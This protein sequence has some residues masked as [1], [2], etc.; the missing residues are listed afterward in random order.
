MQRDG[1]GLLDGSA[2]MEET[3]PEED[4]GEREGDDDAERKVI[5]FGQ[6]RQQGR[7]L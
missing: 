6:R 1:S 2:T 5:E 7:A 3:R 4:G